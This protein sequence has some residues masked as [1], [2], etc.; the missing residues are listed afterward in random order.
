M[1]DGSRWYTHDGVSAR[2]VQNN[3]ASYVTTSTTPFSTAPAE[4]AV[5]LSNNGGTWFRFQS[6]FRLSADDIASHASFTLDLTL[7]PD[8]LVTAGPS[9]GSGT[10][11]E[12]NDGGDIKQIRLPALDL[13]PVAHL[14]TAK[15]VRETY[16]ADVSPGDFKLR[17]ELYSIDGDPQR[18]VYGVGAR[19]IYKNRT[20]DVSDFS[21]ISF[22]EM[23]PNGLEFQVWDKSPAISDMARGEKVGDTVTATVHC[24]QWGRGGGGSAAVIFTGCPASGVVPVTFTLQSIATL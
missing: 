11:V 18:T 8:G 14:D 1:S 20:G 15:A 5:V 16:N 3:F 7:D 19:V 2:V 9:P 23:K 24:Q 13:T 4:E 21:K 10:L 22:L 17:V 6:P 12:A